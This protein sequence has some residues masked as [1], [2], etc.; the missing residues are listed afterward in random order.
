MDVATFLSKKSIELRP[1]FVVAGDEAFL[2]RLVLRRLREVALGED[3]DPATITSYALEQGRSGPTFAAV[4]D[5]LE[6]APFFSKRRVIVIESADDFVSDH[7][8]LLEK[9]ID[10]NLLPATG[11]LILEVKT[12]ASNTR[13][14]K[15]ID[16]SSTIICKSPQ[17]FRLPQWAAEWAGSAYGKKLSMEA[18]QLLIEMVEPELGLIDQEL[19]KLAVYVG[20]RATITAEDVDTLVGNNRAANTWKIFDLI[21]AGDS[22]SALRLLQRLL[23]QG[24]DPMK[25]V[26]ALMFQLRKLGQATYLAVIEKRPMPTALK[27][28]GIAPFGLESAHKQLQ[29]LTRERALR[30]YDELIAL[31]MDLRGNSPLD[32]AS[33]LERFILR[34]A[35]KPKSTVSVA[36]SQI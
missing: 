9:K 20:D 29:H 5:E 22:D 30:L 36:K 1:L 31:N 32:P 33:L 25:L 21:G 2:K 23:Q 28:A 27:D 4:W 14:A 35:A 17:A 10:K 6:S 12:W 13:L 26:G 11:V 24:E 7:R 3:G 15:M 8:G 18:A 34:L 19:A 16:D